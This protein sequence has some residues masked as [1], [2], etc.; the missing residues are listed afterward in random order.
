[1]KKSI[2]LFFMGA[3]VSGTAWADCDRKVITCSNGNKTLL[4]YGMANGEVVKKVV[5]MIQS[6]AKGGVAGASTGGGHWGAV[7]GALTGA[8]GS[9]FS[10]QKEGGVLKTIKASLC[11]PLDGSVGFPWE[12]VQKVCRAETV[13][14]IAK[15]EDLTPEV[16]EVMNAHNAAR[17]NKENG[18]DILLPEGY[19]KCMGDGFGIEKFQCSPEEDAKI[20]A[21]MQKNPKML[22]WTSLSESQS[23]A[24]KPFTDLVTA[25]LGE[26]TVIKSALQKV[27]ALGKTSDNTAIQA[28]AKAAEAKLNKNMSADIIQ[29]TKKALLDSPSGV[30]QALAAPMDK[31][32]T[33]E[34]VK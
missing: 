31:I 13:A 3:W 20:T 5:K 29:D 11:A 7:A 10:A 30:L 34:N 19:F 15:V 26:G 8:V 16:Q 27:Q 32:L 21:W 18:L 17:K 12:N 25:S 9:L 24:I 23:N 14:D 33:Q 28:L 4:D 22:K 6:M 1:M 2:A